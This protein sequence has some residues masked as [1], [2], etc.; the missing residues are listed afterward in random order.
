MYKFQ[1]YDSCYSALAIQSEYKQEYITRWYKT[2]QVNSYILFNN[3][4]TINE[5]VF[6]G[7]IKFNLCLFRVWHR[8]YF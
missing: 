3:S 5:S 8:H 4:K 6:I 7:W 1:G 2:V